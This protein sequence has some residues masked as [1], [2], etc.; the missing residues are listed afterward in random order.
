MSV[1]LTKRWSTEDYHI[2]NDAE[3]VVDRKS[4]HLSNELNVEGQ[5]YLSE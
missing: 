5:I 1:G 2:Q 4:G 3:T